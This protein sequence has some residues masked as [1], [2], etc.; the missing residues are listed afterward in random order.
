MPVPG[1]RP[2]GAPCPSRRVGPFHVI[3]LWLVA[4]ASLALG[5][6]LSFV[7]R[8][9]APSAAV[10]ASQSDVDS[11]VDEEEEGGDE[12]RTSPEGEI[13]GLASDLDGRLP[14]AWYHGQ[15]GYLVRAWPAIPLRVPPDVDLEAEGKPPRATGRHGVEGSMG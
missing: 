3:F 2:R 14:D 4:F 9:P 15:L 7:T 10:S 8:A 11:D 1:S 6:A 13:D 5:P 12:E